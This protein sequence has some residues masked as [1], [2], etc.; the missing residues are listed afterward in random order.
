MCKMQKI[1]ARAVSFLSFVFLISWN[2]F[3]DSS[4]FVLFFFASSI[5]STLP[6]QETLCPVLFDCESTWPFWFELNFYSKGC[7]ENIVLFLGQMTMSKKLNPP[8]LPPLPPP[9][10]HPICFSSFASRLLPSCSIVTWNFGSHRDKLAF[11]SWISTF[12]IPLVFLAE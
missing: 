3:L 9:P 4:T 7:M 2:V 6:P 11:N 10:R 8:T 5:C 1:Y 12:H